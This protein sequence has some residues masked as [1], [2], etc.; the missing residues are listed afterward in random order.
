LTITPPCFV[1]SL[2]EHLSSFKKVQ[3]RLA[4]M[5]DFQD[6]QPCFH[7]NI[8]GNIRQNKGQW[9]MA[10]GSPSDLFA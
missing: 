6:F 2:H 4:H 5:A 1:L 7:F 10:D 8:M 3:E 9:I